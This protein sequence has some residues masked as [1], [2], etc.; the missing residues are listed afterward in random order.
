MSRV[1]REDVNEV[2]HLARLAL[3]ETQLAE[4]AGQLEA[5]LDYV[6]VLD[7]IDTEGV[8]PTSHVLSLATPLRDDARTEAL[9][10][11]LAVANAPERDGTAFVVPK[12]IEGEDEG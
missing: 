12:V 2:A 8:P 11:E 9:P 4:A 10:P 3:D 6:A 7:A 1:S 5:M